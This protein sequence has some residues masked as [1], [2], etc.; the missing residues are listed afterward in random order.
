[1]FKT[2]KNYKD[3]EIAITEFINLNGIDNETL[4]DDDE[5]KELASVIEVI[6]K[7]AHRDGEDDSDLQVINF[8]NVENPRSKKL[9]S[10]MTRH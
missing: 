3:L 10:I 9:L 7:D 5:C 4:L 1:M 6:F 8:H 2:K